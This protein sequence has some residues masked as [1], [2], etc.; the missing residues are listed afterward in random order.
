L[1]GLYF[2]GFQS[3]TSQFSRPKNA[4]RFLDRSVIALLYEAASAEKP[5]T[6]I[7]F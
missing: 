6:L 3:L 7:L 2:F 4:Q 1:C 5:K